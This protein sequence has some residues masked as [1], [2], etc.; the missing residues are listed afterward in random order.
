M[1]LFDSLTPMT[2]EKNTITLSMSKYGLM[3]TKTTLEAL[4]F[5][6]YVEVSVDEKK[7]LFGIRSAKEA[8]EHTRNFVKNGRKNSELYVKW[9]TRDIMTFISRCMNIDLFQLDSTIKVAGTFDIS[10]YSIVFYLSRT[11]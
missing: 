9:N 11:V 8:N 5:P 2:S 10:D 6:R 3:F 1:S 7:K 4:N